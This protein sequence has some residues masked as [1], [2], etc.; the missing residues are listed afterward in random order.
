MLQS[1]KTPLITTKDSLSGENCAVET[2][3]KI[4]FAMLSVRE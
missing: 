2:D 1:D 3:S 4:N